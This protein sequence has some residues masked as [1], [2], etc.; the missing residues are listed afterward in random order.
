MPTYEVECFVECRVVYE[1]LAADEDQARELM[2]HNNYDPL[3]PELVTEIGAVE[4]VGEVR[5]VTA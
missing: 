1:V 5:E 4:R 3:G 2:A